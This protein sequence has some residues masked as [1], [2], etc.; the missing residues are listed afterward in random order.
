MT[1]RLNKKPSVSRSRIF[2]Q[3]LLVL[4]AFL[5]CVVT[6]VL[7]LAA[8]GKK[9]LLRHQGTNITV[10][11]NYVQAA[12]NDG[13]NITYNGERYQYN[14]KVTN[15][16]IMGIDRKKLSQTASETYGANGQADVLFLVSLDTETGNMTVIPISR[17]TM[18]DIDLYAADGQYLGV[19]NQQICLSFSY[20]DGRKKSCENT[21]TAVSRLLYG[22]PIHSY[23]AIDLDAIRLLNDAIGGVT[24][25]V[26]EDIDLYSMHLKKG[27]TVT[28]KG[29][30]A[31]R[32]IR[33]RDQSLEANNVRMERQKNYAKAF[34]SQTIQMTKKDLTTPIRLYNRLGDYKVSNL[35]VADISFLTK[36]VLLN[37]KNDT[38]SFTTI[39]GDLS[40]GASYVEL[41]ADK[42]ALYKIVL[43]T[44]YTK[45]S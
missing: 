37:H 3:I 11:S 23:L 27:D 9:R 35:G 34:Y 14:E 31:L 25:T 26:N 42:Q 21:C 4:L 24:V 7:I 16:L 29:S 41:R 39:P 44:F 45:I 2:L 22:M 13:K 38:V 30:Y 17:D 33:G 36:C 6:T 28:L 10:P 32:Y 43:D 12:E 15:I 19:S 20:G 5:L 18:V 40:Q 8:V 1:N